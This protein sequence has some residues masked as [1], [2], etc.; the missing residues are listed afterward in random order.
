MSNFKKIEDWCDWKP[1]EDFHSGYSGFEI[2]NLLIT[3]YNEM[4][5]TLVVLNNNLDVKEDS[6]NI[7]L[8]RKLSVNGDFTGTWFGET[9][10]SVDAKLVE[11]LNNYNSLISYLIA[12]PQIGWTIWDGKFFTTSEP[13]TSILDGGEFTDYNT[14][15][16]DCGAFIYPCECLS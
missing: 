15:E 9:K 12:N 14:D 2:M 5:D 16:V 13:V 11:G 7:T 1:P 10:S 6:E 8:N 3:K 4:I